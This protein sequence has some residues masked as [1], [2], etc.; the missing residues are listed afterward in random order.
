MN[1][2]EMYC[3]KCKKVVN[4]YFKRVYKATLFSPEEYDLVCSE[5]GSPNYLEEIPVSEV[6]EDE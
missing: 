5:C 1:P 6:D 4:V 2:D 3:H